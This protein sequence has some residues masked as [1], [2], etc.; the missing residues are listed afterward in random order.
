[1]IG[2]DKV[3]EQ[4]AVGAYAAEA[5]ARKVNAVV[6]FDS[7]YEF[8]LGRL[9]AHAPVGARKFQCRIGALRPR[10]GKKSVI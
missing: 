6:A 5:C 7:A 3:A 4:F 10:V 9:T 2:I 1:V 8:S